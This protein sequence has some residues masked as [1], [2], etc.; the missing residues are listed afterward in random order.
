VGLKYGV[1]LKILK[2]APGKTCDELYEDISLVSSKQRFTITAFSATPD[3]AIMQL[4]QW[5]VGLL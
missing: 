5:F 1:F 2:R 3:K 4:K